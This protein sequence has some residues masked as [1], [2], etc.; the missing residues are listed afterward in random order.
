MCNQMDGNVVSDGDLFPTEG[1]S[2]CT[3]EIF[4]SSEYFRHKLKRGSDADSLSI[5]GESIHS[6]FSHTLF[7]KWQK[8][9]NLYS[10]TLAPKFNAA[11]QNPN[12]R[13]GKIALASDI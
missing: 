11:K 10:R 1:F 4:H 3:L 9:F 5:W 2:Y 8:E 6:D 12:T 13:N 7:W